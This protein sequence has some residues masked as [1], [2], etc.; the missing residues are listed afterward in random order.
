MALSGVKQIAYCKRRFCLMNVD[1]EWGSNF[2]IAEGDILHKRVN[3]PYFNE[4]RGSIHISRSVPVYSEQYCL[5]GIAD[6]VE[7][8]QDDNGVCI[9]GKKGLWKIN[10]VEYKNGKPEK[11]D[12]DNYQLCAQALCLEEMFGCNIASG[13]VYYGKLKRRKTIQFDETIRSRTAGYIALMAQLLEQSKLPPVPE[14]QNCN[15]CSLKDV[16]LPNAVLE[17]EGR[18]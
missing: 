10:P 9:A 13:D 8:I 15:L 1:G 17:R 16:C 11:S 3:D 18:P 2:K 14:G 5:Y 6:I 7:F 4:K 12:A